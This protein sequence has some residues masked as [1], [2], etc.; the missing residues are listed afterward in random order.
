MLKIKAK[1][2]ELLPAKPPKE[3]GAMKGKKGSASDAPP[4]AKHTIS[5][6]RKLAK[7]RDKL[8]TYYEG[9]DDVPTQAGFLEFVSDVEENK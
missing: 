8:E 5:A 6:Y 9:V 2:G 1:L 3:T 4:F 7:H